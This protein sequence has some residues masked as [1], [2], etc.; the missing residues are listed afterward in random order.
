MSSGVLNTHSSSDVFR[1]ATQGLLRVKKKRSCSGNRRFRGKYKFLFRPPGCSKV[2]RF[3]Q[4]LEIRISCDCYGLGLPAN[5][6]RA[7]LRGVQPFLWQWATTVF[8]G[9]FEG[10]LWKNH[11]RWYTSYGDLLQA[12][13]SGD[14]ISVGARFSI[15][16]ETALGPTQPP[17]QWVPGLFSGGKAAGTWR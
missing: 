4:E 6:F 1:L 13:R 14:R 17:I 5:I 8:A 9:R 12:V 3:I 16:V 7:L 11:N 15:P 10:R 2:L